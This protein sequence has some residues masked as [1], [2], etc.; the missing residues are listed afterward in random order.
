MKK[1]KKKNSALYRERFS[2]DP[3]FTT[4]SLF[5]T[6]SEVCTIS[7]KYWIPKK[8][9]YTKCL[10]PLFHFKKVLSIGSFEKKTLATVLL[11]FTGDKVCNISKN[12]QNID[13]LIQE[14]SYPS[15]IS[16]N[17]WCS[18]VLRSFE[19]ST[20]YHIFATFSSRWGVIYFKKIT[21][22]L[23]NQLKNIFR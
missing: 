21:K 11:V 18:L 10:I 5:L 16:K 1:K 7:N 14:A 12:T 9:F 20:F 6:V 17:S 3:L 13:I 23:I 8:Y 2:K 15:F 19:I 22:F 4:F